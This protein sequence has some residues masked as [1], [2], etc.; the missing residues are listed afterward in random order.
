MKF[1]AQEMRAGG[2]AT[3]GR[4]DRNV[5]SRGWRTLASAIHGTDRPPDSTRHTATGGQRGASGMRRHQ[6]KEMS[7]HR[8]AILGPR[9]ATGGGVALETWGIP[10]QQGRGIGGTESRYGVAHLLR[11]HHDGVPQQTR[12]LGSLPRHTPAKKCSFAAA[13]PRG[14]TTSGVQLGIPRYVHH[15]APAQQCSPAAA[16]P[17]GQA[18]GGVRLRIPTPS[19]DISIPGI[20]IP[21]I[22]ESQDRSSGR[23]SALG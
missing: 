20:S 4:V 14:R 7:V 5:D 18:P 23:C 21:G 19:P 1:H 9:P 22:T 17:R 11:F 6:E 16:L 10:P 3:A 12:P 8:G 15:L 2:G 13:P